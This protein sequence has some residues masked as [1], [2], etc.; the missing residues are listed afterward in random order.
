KSKSFAPRAGLLQKATA[1]TEPPFVGAATRGES[2]PRPAQKQKLRPEGW[3]QEKPK[4]IR[5]AFA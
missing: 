2:G 4:R 5:S 1:R 3:P